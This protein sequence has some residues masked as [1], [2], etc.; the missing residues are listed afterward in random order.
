MSIDPDPSGVPHIEESIRYLISHYDNFEFKKMKS[1]EFFDKYRNQLSVDF[2]GKRVL[3]I[4]DGDHSAYGCIR[5]LYDF[6]SIGAGLILVDDTVWLPH[7]GRIAR[8]FAKRKGY[9]FFDFSL[10]NG[11]G[12]LYKKPTITIGTSSV[13][14]KII[15]WLWFFGNN[16]NF[17]H[18]TVKFVRKVKSIIKKYF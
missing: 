18:T 4:I 9:E 14:D 2:K 16:T 11:M 8:L 6:Y 12:I 17:L 3:G 15:Y 5:D 1:S 7:I 13:F 10:Y